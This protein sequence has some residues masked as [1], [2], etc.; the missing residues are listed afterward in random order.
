MNKMILEVCSFSYEGCQIAQA[1][2]A[3]RIELCSNALEGGTT[4]S[5][6]L[7]KKVRENIHLKIY[8]II[9]PRGGDFLYTSDELDIMKHEIQLC[10]ELGCDGI[11]TGIQIADGR[12]DMDQMKRIVEI[13]WP[14][15][16]TCIRAFDI[17]PD[18]YEAIESLID[19]GCERI[20]TSG[21]A[22]SAIEGAEAINKFIN[23][24]GNRIII[25]PGSGIRADNINYLVQHTGAHEFHT[26][27]R[28]FLPDNVSWHSQTI[29]NKD[30][31][32]AVSCDFKQIKEIRRL[33]D[34]SS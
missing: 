28:I 30:F 24:A 22:A 25:M 29:T 17:V 21:M 3:D 18:P 10:K 32:Q 1:A 27:A 13:A 31:G 11:A 5:Y 26:S 6:G 8:P 33:L 15:K 12:I 4:P 2:G 16:V 7:V 9:R 14:M 34:T 20:L 19:A 23:Y